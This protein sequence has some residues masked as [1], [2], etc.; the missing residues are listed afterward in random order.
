M[1]R[2]IIPLWLLTVLTGGY[3][4]TGPADEKAAS[5]PASPGAAP[6]APVESTHPSTAEAFPRALALKDSHRFPE[7]IQAFEDLLRNDPGHPE[8]HYHTAILLGIL[9]PDDPE[10]VIH[11]EQALRLSPDNETY[12]NAL[13][14]ARL[15]LDLDE[16]ALAAYRDLRNRHPDKP[17][18]AYQTA[19]ILVKQRNLS[20]ALKE[21]EE[22]LAQHGNDPDCLALKGRI[23]VL[24]GDPRQAEPL[25]RTALAHRPGHLIALIELAKIE[26]QRGEWRAVE[27]RLQAALEVNPF[28]PEIHNRLGAAYQAL[29]RKEE[30]RGRLDAAQRLMKLGESQK[31]FLDYL[32]REGPKTFPEHLVLA[33]EFVQLGLHA[34]AA[35][36]YELARRADPEDQ[37]VLV[38]LALLYL[39]LKNPEEAYRTID[40]LHDQNE[41]FSEAALT[42]LGWSAFL[43]GR[44]EVAQGAVAAARAH[45][46]TSE[47]LTAL[48]A[49]LENRPRAWDSRIGN[50]LAILTV[51]FLCGILAALRRRKKIP[52]P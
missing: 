27:A 9:K 44:V 16:E 41:W 49:A 8:Y 40:R 39:E 33:R 20:A 21:L 22:V 52:A 4:W 14:E 48:A 30:A 12:A 37:T 15:R 26:A 6:P 38:P 45:S 3:S 51:I 31:A 43:T 7:A 25:L 23:L 19:A 1:H 29:G 32:I 28:I 42:A 24:T 50:P 18:Y 46:V 2:L 34:M 10:A 5:R 11:L 35:R 47:R 17:R 13:A 36:L